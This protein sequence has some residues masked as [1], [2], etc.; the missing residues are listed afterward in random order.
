MDSMELEREKGI[1]IQSAATYCRWKNININIID[2]PGHVDFT[3]EV[4]RALRVLDSAILVLCAVSGV[5][6]QT[7]TVD[8]Q[9]R[10]YDIPRIAFINK[11][12]RMGA[13]PMLVIEKMRKILGH[14]C[15]AI[16]IPIGLDSDFK[17][18]IDLIEE[19][20]IYFE[21]ESGT[22]LRET[23][24][25][26]SFLKITKE[27]RTELIE[28]L[29][30]IDDHIADLFISEQ[31][32]S[33]KDLE[34]S[35]RRLTIE[36]KFIPVCMG[37]AYKNIGVQLLLDSVISYLPCPSE[38]ENEAFQKNVNNDL[39][40][41]GKD[42]VTKILLNSGDSDSD[43]VG[44]AFKLE[45]SRYGQLTYIR[46]YQ[47]TLK[48]GSSIYNSSTLKKFKVP[49]LVRMHSNELED[50][51]SVGAGEICA[52][53]GI[54]CASGDTFTSSIKCPISMTP[55]HVPDPVISLSIRPLSKDTSSQF[56][57][58]LSRFQ[59]EDPTFKVEIDSESD[60]MIISGMGELHLEIYVE[61]MRREY[62][63]P[64]ITGKPKVAYR[65]VI[66][67][68]T[69]FDY[70]HKKQSGGSGQ[71]GRV[72]GY[73]EPVSD[74]YSEDSSN[75]NFSNE[76]IS[77]VSG[78]NV[79]TE[80]IPACQKGF[81]DQ[82]NKGIIT[83]HPIVGCRFVL[84]DGAHHS[85]D[86]NE[87]SFRSAAANAFRE[88]FKNSKPFLLEPIMRVVVNC[89]SE[90]QGSIMGTIN[91]RKGL[92]VNNASDSSIPVDDVDESLPGDSFISFTADV[93]L[94]NMFGY[95]SELRSLTQGKGEFSMEYHTY[96]PVPTQITKEME[97]SFLKRRLKTAN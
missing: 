44:L 88:A 10:R 13:N 46:I 38:V 64:C 51:D 86:S 27:K 91:R 48:R 8:R 9:M 37:S 66:T 55:M 68:M 21:G 65:E 47:G 96:A 15:A 16:Q 26:P 74:W 76:F 59:R 1:T 82:T 72:I 25:P 71:F 11:L 45:E 57:K 30:N 92:I 20:A 79:P 6:S 14:V 83:G 54:E 4:E 80:Y 32:P 22:I 67:E 77:K 5:Q 63:C 90:F 95:S 39:E 29:A 50:V 84:E 41:G 81:T 35:I 85:V 56:S 17:G 43:F 69:T 28:C 62:N 97:E 52:M 78:G 93:P 12:D 3:I 87:Y 73:I 89:P 34:D 42:E 61:R 75:I 40:G 31:K 7:M 94:S 18:I 19:K 33:P 49:R 36:R 23:P 70:T 24:I 58:A 2:T 53:F 60:E